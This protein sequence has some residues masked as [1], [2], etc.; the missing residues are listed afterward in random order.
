[1]GGF[2]ATKME[3]KNEGEEGFACSRNNKESE[4]TS[5]LSNKI[6]QLVLKNT[7]ESKFADSLRIIPPS[8]KSIL[9]PIFQSVKNF[10]RLQIRK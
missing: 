7:Q 9:L 6:F 8:S 10:I 5:V 3:G 4:K 2:F 1:M